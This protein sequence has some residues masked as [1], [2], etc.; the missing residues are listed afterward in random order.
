MITP[1]L[2]RD[3]SRPVGDRVADLLGRMTTTEK[4]AQLGSAWVFQL[5]AGTALTPGARTIMEHGL[6][7]V[8]RISGASNVASTAAADL[9]NTIQRHLVE[10]T[11]LGI[12]AIVHEEVCA[13]LMARGATVFPQPI[14]LASAWDPSLVER[15]ATIVRDEMRAI[16]AHQGLS[17]VLD[18][19]RDPRWGR[20]E[21]TFGEDPHLVAMMG[22]AF[23]RGLQGADLATGVVAT[24]KHLVGYGASEGGLNWAPAHIPARELHEVY[25]HPF[26]AAVRTAGLRSV[27]NAYNELDGIPCGAS[28]ELLTGTLRD[29]WGFDGYVVADYFAVR[30]LENYHHL[31]ADAADA[32]AMALEAGLD[33]ELPMTDCYGA[34]LVDA[35][36]A[37]IVAVEVLDRAVERVLRTKFELGLFESPFVDVGHAA[38]LVGSVESRQ[39]ARTL[40]ERSIVLLRND[41]VLPLGAST[42][43]TI[44]VIGPNADDPRNLFGDYSYAA[45]VE[46]L[47]EMRDS[48]NVFHVPI[49]DGFDLD[50]DVVGDRTVAQAIA[51]AFPSATVRTTPGCTVNGAGRDGFDDA[52][53]L[54]AESDVAVM[55]MGD[56]AGLTLDST[57]GESRDRSSLDLPGVQEALVRAVL[58]TGTPVV[59]VL[60]AGRPCGSVDAHEGCAAVVAAWLPGDE[61]AA[62]IADVLSGVVNPG[63]KLPVSF[64]RTAGHIPVYYRHKQSGGRSHW[65]GDYVDASVSPMYPFGHGLSYTSFELTATAPTPSIIGQDD[66]IT[67]AV[68]VT[69]TGPR[70]GDEVVQLYTRDPQ[71][72]LTRPVLELKAF[73]RV[74]VGAGEQRTVTFTIHAGQLG[75]YD[76]Q[77]RYVI[78]PGDIEVHIGTSVTQ[79]CHVGTFTI[80]TTNGAVEIDKVFDARVR[81]SG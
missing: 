28:H 27:M 81:L 68:S 60:V 9:A 55:V 58:A 75:F 29:H 32:A 34:P 22:N 67:V 15:M 38:G 13:G 23:V 61:G 14:G 46:S 57:S 40:A 17:P 43:G 77:L 53:R 26:E 47:L 54:A 44:A 35:V 76:R 74:S 45:H 71:A 1:M 37:G 3:S 42:T 8:T 36:D 73:A 78:E 12:P 24:A 2:Y 6:G 69:N 20:I 11:R 4:V 10:E 41:G 21:E 31:A 66:E 70:D 50:L 30:Q 79:L 59:L 33:V 39:F 72:S 7:Q 19:C 80:A 64:P 51:A 16:G 5:V 48:D 49:P 52:T 63:G 18:L 62:A 25:L 65:K 56:K